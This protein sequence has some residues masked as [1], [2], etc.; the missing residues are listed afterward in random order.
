MKNRANALTLLSVLILLFTLIVSAWPVPDT[1]QT[2]CYDNT[3][4]ITCLNQSEA[5]YGQNSNFIIKSNPYNNLHTN[6]DAYTLTVMET[7]AYNLLII[8]AGNMPEWYNSQTTGID[9]ANEVLAGA[10]G[11][12]IDLTQ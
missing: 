12:D 5:F 2:K 1:G 3:A 4:K 9:A 11:I 7:G 8:D 10:T 6:I